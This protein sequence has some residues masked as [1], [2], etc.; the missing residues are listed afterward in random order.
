MWWAALYG[1]SRSEDW[2]AFDD[3]AAADAWQLAHP[4]GVVWAAPV[5]EAWQG[6]AQAA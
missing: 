6:D 5:P 4:T 3:E 1:T 2:L